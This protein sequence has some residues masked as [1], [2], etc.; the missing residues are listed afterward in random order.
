MSTHATDPVAVAGIEKTIW[1]IDP[2]RSGV[3]FNA[4]GLWGIATVKGRFSRYQGTLHLSGQ[5]AIELT[6]EADSLDT[7][8]D[9]RDRHLRSPDF[10]DVEEHPYIRFVSQSA[11]LEG[12]RL[13]V[14]GLL[15]ARG[16]SMPLD[17][18]AT[19][20]RAG[21]ELDVEAVTV[22]DHHQLGMTWNRLA[23]VGR[24]S[25]LVVEG[26]LVRDA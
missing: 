2:E 22:A 1:R 6:I 21:D 18:D 16:A 20:R 3:E 14:R 15:H 26:R 4:K 7:N 10:F 24:S 11:A 5:P 19:L 13:K 9:K 12:E 8:N 23:M 17:I 25:K